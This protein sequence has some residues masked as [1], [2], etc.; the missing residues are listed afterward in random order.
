M[1][2]VVLMKLKLEEVQKVEVR[3]QK[4][5]RLLLVRCAEVCLYRQLW[6]KKMTSAID[7]TLNVYLLTL[8][9]MI[10]YLFSRK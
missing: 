7:K 5:T 1:L 9:K 4:M 3:R 10:F 8:S 6:K 2:T